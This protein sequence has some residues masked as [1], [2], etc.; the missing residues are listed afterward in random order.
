MAFRLGVLV[1]IL[2]V[3]SLSIPVTADVVPE[4]P[5]TY[6]PVDISGFSDSISHWRAK[7]GRDRKDPRFDPAQIVEIA[8]NLL[9]YQNADGGWPKNVDWLADIPETEVRRLCGDGLKKST[10]DNRNTYTQVEYL[11]RVFLQTGDPAH[12]AAAE[13]GLDYVLREQRPTGGWCGADVDAITFN[14]GVMTG[15]MRLLLSVRSGAPE[16]AWLDDAR[17]R[18]AGEALDR[19]LDC[20]LA[21]QIT[22]NGRKTAWCQQHDHATF[23]PVKARTYELPSITAGE[24]TEVLRLLTALPDPDKRVIAA[25]EAGAAWLQSVRIE[26]LRVEKV[27][28]EPVRFTHHTATSDTVVVADPAAPPLW[29]RFYDLETEKPFLCRRDGTRV[30]TLAKVELER[31]SGY[32]W[33]GRWPAAFLE[34]DYP[35]WRKRLGLPELPQ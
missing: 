12:R 17:S 18:A 14:D 32:G 26:G 6:T 5:V 23:A 13:R 20:V 1:Q 8:A 15:I 21:C 31:R 27:P 24:S 25:V 30:E 2:A 29:A 28:I 22:V 34:K 11:A 7:L 33:Y 19:A 10:L 4:S 35:A 16:F 9:R 3:L